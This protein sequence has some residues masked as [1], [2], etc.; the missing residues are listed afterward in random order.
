MLLIWGYYLIKSNWYFL[1]NHNLILEGFLSPTA[2]YQQSNFLISQRKMRNVIFLSRSSGYREMCVFGIKVMLNVISLSNDPKRIERL[3]SAVHSMT[4]REH[5][6]TNSW[7]CYRKCC[8]KYDWNHWSVL[9][10][11]PNM[12]FNAEKIT[13]WSTLSCSEGKFRKNKWYCLTLKQLSRKE[14]CFSDVANFTWRLSSFIKVINK[15]IFV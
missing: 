3:N 1:I 4:V 10:K 8:S 2:E 6:K 13:L 12:F 5:L 15:R 11:T 14:G 7:T 9:S